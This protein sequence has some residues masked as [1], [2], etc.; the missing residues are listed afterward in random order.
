LGLPIAKKIVEMHKGVI[1]IESKLGAG[2]TF[3]VSLPA[4]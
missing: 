3:T 4:E 2:A 1:Q